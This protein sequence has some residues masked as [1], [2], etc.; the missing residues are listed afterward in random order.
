MN[1]GS[2]LSAAWQ[3]LAERAVVEYR[4]ALGSDL[5]AV[6]CFGSVARG[7]PEPDSDLGISD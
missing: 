6:A 1:R 3:A 7:T 2:A 4:E 5:L